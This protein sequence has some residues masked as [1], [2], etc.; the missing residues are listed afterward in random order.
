[1]ALYVNSNISSLNAARHLANATGS[2]DTAFKRL[3]SG[4]RINS[5]KDDA[6]GLQISDRLTAQING[7]EQGNR[8]AQD[9]ISLCQTAEGA[10]DEM[11]NMYQRIRTLALQSANGTNSAA[12]RRAI[13]Q[14]INQLCREIDR[15][16]TDTTYGGTHLFDKSI[17]DLIEFQVGSN[18]H[19]TVS[20]DLTSGFRL[21]DVF[22]RIYS[23][24]ADPE[25]QALLQSA[26]VKGGVSGDFGDPPV[27][28]VEAGSAAPNGEYGVKV[29]QLATGV[30]VERRIPITY[31]G[32]HMNL[33]TISAGYG[34]DALSFTVGIPE[35]WDL[36]AL[37]NRINNASD[38]FGVVAD[39]RWVSNSTPTQSGYVFRLKSNVTG[40]DFGN[41]SVTTTM[42]NAIQLD[43]FYDFS[44][45]GDHDAN[46]NWTVKEQ[47]R[48][49]IVEIDGDVL[50]SNDMVVYDPAR[51]MT[52][53]V[54]RL[55][56]IDD[57]GNGFRP[58]IV[59]VNTD[60]FFAADT[61][62]KAQKTLAVVDK[63][64]AAIDSKRAELGAVQN[65]LESSI[66][67]QANVSENVSAA[68]SRIHD[69]DFATESA[70][71]IQ[72][73]I[74]QQAAQSILSQANQRPQIALSLLQQ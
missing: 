65:R 45:D 14:E 50:T 67:N 12:D 51:D 66:R 4:L 54:N 13:Q 29:T 15:I 9:G 47:A 40:T 58:N 71:M 72:R 21:D 64:I 17:T 1:M 42:G 30:T 27:F 74:L 62:E 11:T 37:P 57:S 34:S 10:L 8:N 24:T 39:V 32:Q 18:D 7:L 46:G 63:F 44:V 69:A 61:P 53:N 20:V 22:D 70:A 19:E 5:A 43:S 60:S 73:N 31:P 68:R 49:T 48:D 36:S 23:D 16:G 52:I 56:D 28:D 35:T 2:L 55:S 59:R 6:A 41:L 33:V 38:N 3:A 26:V 25:E